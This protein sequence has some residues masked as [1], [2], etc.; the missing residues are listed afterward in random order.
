MFIRDQRGSAFQAKCLLV[1]EFAVVLVSSVLFR[2]RKKF[3][4]LYAFIVFSPDLSMNIS[5]FSKTVHTISIKFCPVILHPNVHP[6]ASAMASKSYNWDVG[7]SPNLPENDQKTAIFQLFLFSEN[8]IRFERNFLQS[9]YT[10]LGSYMC[11][12]ID[13]LTVIRESQMEK[14]LSRLLYARAALVQFPH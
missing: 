8:S 6:P 14:D 1:A 7:N 3:N 2:S 5:N 4:Y 9:F 10:I 12:F 13:R 11:N